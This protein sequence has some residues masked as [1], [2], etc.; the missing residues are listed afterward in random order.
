[1]SA[2]PRFLRQ[3]LLVLAVLVVAATSC[4]AAEGERALAEPDSAAPTERFAVHGQVTF[5][6]QAT[7]D[8]T[9]PYAGANSLSPRIGRETVDATLSLGLR[10]GTGRELWISPE[11]DQGFGL[12]DTLGVAGFPSAEAYKVGRRT[13]YLRWPRLF[14]R[15][16]LN[17]GAPDQ[18]VDGTAIQLAGRQS[19]DRLVFTLGKFSVVDVFD[20]NNYAHD[21][22]GDFLNW[23][24]VDAGSFDYAADAWGYTV[25]A[26][27]EWYEGRW[28]LRLGLFDLSDVPNSPHLEPA[29]HEFQ[30]LVELER[31]HELAGRPGKLMLTFFDS[32]GRMALLADAIQLAESTGGAVDPA[33][34]R[35]YRDRYGV[36]LNVEQ[37]LSGSVGLFLRGGGASGNV[38]AYEFTDIDRTVSGGV[39]IKGSSWD[40]AGDTVGFAA[41][42]ND[43]SQVR[44]RFLAAGGLGILVGDGRLPHPGRE[45][46][47]EAYYDLAIVRQAHFDFDY[48]FV[49]NPA[50]NS[51][52]GP[53]SIFAIRLHAQF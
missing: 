14:I 22:R 19:N 27:A 10:I 47:L 42:I 43:I 40:R 25:G 7:S 48:Q 20:A 49:R 35:R 2:H 4:R 24:V 28:T 53:V 8:F 17:L 41:V 3:L 39:S 12:D 9:A 34:V 31:R 32:R 6:E 11:I 50:Y 23:A 13:P 51:D 46:I 5:V 52:R 37:E 16:T 26:A 21:P 18:P 38:E 29:F 44:K 36:H 1:M 15:Q 33:A 45:Q 30:K